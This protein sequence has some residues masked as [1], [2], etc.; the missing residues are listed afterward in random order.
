MGENEDEQGEAATKW[1]R[2]RLVGCGLSPCRSHLLFLCSH[3]KCIYIYIYIKHW[4]GL[5]RWSVDCEASTVLVGRLAG[6][7]GRE[8]EARMGESLG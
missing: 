3:V 2:D 1:G 8:R 4:G 7:G 6:L 5:G